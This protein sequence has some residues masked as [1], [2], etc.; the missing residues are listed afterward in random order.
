VRLSSSKLRA[1]SQ[2]NR[3]ESASCLK[4]GRS[5][6]NFSQVVHQELKFGTQSARTADRPLAFLAP[7]SLLESSSA[8]LEGKKGWAE[9]ENQGILYRKID[10]KSQEIMQALAQAPLYKKQ[11]MVTARMAQA[12]EQITT[13]LTGDKTETVNTAAA[14]D[15]VVTNPSGEQYIISEQK[16]LARYE[17]VDLAA[18]VYSAKGYCRAIQNPFGEPIEIMASWGSPQNGDAN[19]MIADTCDSNGSCDGE[20]YLIDSNSFS[21][22]YKEVKKP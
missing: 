5:S 13:K 2:T 21:Q 10:R 6:S 16:F 17:R 7:K 15:W 12:G 4:E 19:C 18:S 3:G 8:D 1:S 22:T 11:G 20:P 9:M 14:G